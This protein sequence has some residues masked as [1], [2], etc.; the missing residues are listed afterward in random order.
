MEKVKVLVCHPD[1]TEE[2]IERERE[3]TEMHTAM[4]SNTARLAALESAMLA[5]MG[6]AD[7]V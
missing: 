2:W 5:M 7:N 3:E 1:G 6:G 4:P